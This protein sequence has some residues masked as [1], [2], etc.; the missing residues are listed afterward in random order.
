MEILRFLHSLTRWGVIIVTLAVVAYLLIGW[1]SSR[2][3]ERR[4]ATLMSLFSSLVGVQW[5]LGVV[6][7]IVMLTAGG[8]GGQ[9]WGHVVVM[10]LALFTAHGHFMMRRRQLDDKA[11]YQRY[12]GI[13]VITLLLVLVGIFALPSG[14]QWRFYTPA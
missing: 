7:L 10:T 13:V 4:G 3:W 12:L 5:L 2:R 11:R 9:T 14:I 1:L 6:L 8:V